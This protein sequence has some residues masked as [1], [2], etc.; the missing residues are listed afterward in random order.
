MIVS[1]RDSAELSLDRFGLANADLNKSFK[2][3]GIAN[4]SACTCALYLL[5]AVKNI[6]CRKFHSQH[7]KLI[8]LI[9]TC[10]M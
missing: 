2:L 3:S 7:L 5:G 10:S 8:I 4:Q 6:F 9:N 1:L